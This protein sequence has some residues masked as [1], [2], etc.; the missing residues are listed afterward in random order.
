MNHQNRYHNYDSCSST[1]T[2]GQNDDADDG[3]RSTTTSLLVGGENEDCSSSRSIYSEN[4]LDKNDKQENDGDLSAN[5]KSKCSKSKED[6]IERTNNKSSA[7]TAA[8]TPVM[9]TNNGTAPARAPITTEQ[10]N[11]NSV[12]K[13]SSVTSKYVTPIIHHAT[14]KYDINSHTQQNQKEILSP[15]TETLNEIASAMGATGG[16]DDLRY[17]FSQLSQLTFDENDFDSIH[18]HHHHGEQITSGDGNEATTM[19]TTTKTSTKNVLDKAGG[20]IDSN[21]K[22]SSPTNDNLLLLAQAA[23]SSESKQQ[24]ITL[25]TTRNDKQ[26][27]DEVKLVTT[28]MKGNSSNEQQSCNT[29]EVKLHKPKHQLNE[30]ETKKKRCY[31]RRQ[32]KTVVSFTS[33]F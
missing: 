10:H 33:F 20:N 6:R 5:S 7:P 2:L 30:G 14:P 12:L 4:L 32:Y 22:E 28:K 3:N 29:N 26:T 21:K 11:T 9:A 31:T 17:E 24:K 16:G 8:N 15:A 25:S 1:T 18:H 23:F 19:I 13:S 27:R